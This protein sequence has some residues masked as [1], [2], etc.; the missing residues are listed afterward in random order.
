MCRGR[1]GGRDRWWRGRGRGLAAAHEV[2]AQVHD[3]RVWGVCVG[4][5]GHEPTRS[6]LTRA[7]TP[8]MDQT[9]GG[10]T[11]RTTERQ[12]YSAAQQDSPVCIDPG[13]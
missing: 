8:L 1:G 2:A 4:L 12:T 9:T 6:Q 7:W 3:L 10:R 11:Y 5:R 13:A